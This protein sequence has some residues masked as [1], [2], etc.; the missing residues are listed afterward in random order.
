MIPKTD[1][2]YW[3][4]CPFDSKW[5]VVQVYIRT[6]RRPETAMIGSNKVHWLDEMKGEWGPKVEPLQ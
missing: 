4:K 3:Y 5:T 6:K 1:G 2:L